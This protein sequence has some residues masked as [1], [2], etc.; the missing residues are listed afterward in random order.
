MFVFPHKIVL[1]TCGTTTLLK[2]VPYI[3]EI[4]KTRCGYES[5]YRLFY[6]RKSFM[7]PE[8]QLGPHRSWEEEVNYL[9]NHFGKCLGEEEE[10][11]MSVVSHAVYRQWCFLCDW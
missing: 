1:K 9:D 3:L 7:F 6:S 10:V 2:A 8:K 5:V 4:A 11:N